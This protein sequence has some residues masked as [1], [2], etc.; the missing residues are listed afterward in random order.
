MVE[1]QGFAAR[2]TRL[3]EAL[4]LAPASLP[5]AAAVLA[6]AEPSPE[7]F[8]ALARSMPQQQRTGPPSDPRRR[9]QYLPGFGGVL[10]RLLRNRNLGCGWSGSSTRRRVKGV[11]PAETVGRGE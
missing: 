11:K 10:L 8:L 9:E 3:L 4:E 6:G 1:D 2:L 7:L 5:D